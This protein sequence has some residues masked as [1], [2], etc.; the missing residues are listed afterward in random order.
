MRLTKESE[1][2]KRKQ[3]KE[4]KKHHH[5]HVPAYMRDEVFHEHGVADLFTK[6]EK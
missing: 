5:D 1:P 3:T 2:K 6:K 4:Q